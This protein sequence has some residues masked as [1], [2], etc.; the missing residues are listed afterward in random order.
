MMKPNL[1]TLFRPRKQTNKNRSNRCPLLLSFKSI[2]IID[3][4]PVFF[5]GMYIVSVMHVSD[6]NS[7]SQLVSWQLANFDLVVI[8]VVSAVKFFVKLKL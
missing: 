7:I 3:N 8:W 6:H 1:V 2:T 4:A 5:P